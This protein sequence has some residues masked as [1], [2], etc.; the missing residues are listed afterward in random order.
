MCI[1]DRSTIVSSS[2]L[3][4]ASDII[5]TTE[6]FQNST[7]QPTMMST[8]ALSTLLNTSSS[9]LT[10]IISSTQSIEPSASSSSLVVSSNINASTLV[11]SVHVCDIV[12]SNFTVALNNYTS[13]VLL[14]L[15]PMEV[16]Q[17]CFEQYETMKIFH[18]KIYH[19]CGKHL[20][21]RYNAQYQVIAGLFEIQQRSWNSLEC[22]SEFFVCCIY[23]QGNLISC[24]I[25]V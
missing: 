13:C 22:E 15:K 23:L 14:N 12:A 9:Q 6:I 5:S 20:I 16:C 1:R 17:K 3:Q 25:K 24:S 2:N 21:G 4:N 18:R 11:P 7:I 19:D 8:G 10:T